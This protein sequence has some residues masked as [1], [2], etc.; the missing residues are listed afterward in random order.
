MKTLITVMALM[1]LMAVMLIACTVQAQISDATGILIEDSVTWRRFVSAKAEQA[2]RLQEIRFQAGIDKGK[3]IITQ[4]WRWKQIQ[5][6][7]KKPLVSGFKTRMP[8]K[9]GKKQIKRLAEPVG[10]GHG[11]G[12]LVN[13]VEGIRCKK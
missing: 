5:N 2:K 10:F 7:H 4:A 11:N 6:S 8:V 3:Q 12:Q 13:Y 9:P 1:A